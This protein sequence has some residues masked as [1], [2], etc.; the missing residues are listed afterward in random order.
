MAPI[1]YF[2]YLLHS[3][4]TVTVSPRPS[5][6]KITPGKEGTRQKKK[7]KNPNKITERRLLSSCRGGQA[8]AY[9]VIT[10]Q[11]RHPAAPRR[12]ALALRDPREAAPRHAG[13]PP[14]TCSRSR[15][16]PPTS[17]TAA[18]T[19]RRARARAQARA[20]HLSRRR[21]A[22]LRAGLATPPPASTRAR[23]R[24]RPSSP[25]RAT[26]PRARGEAASRVGRGGR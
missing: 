13:S 3:S 11:G 23:G 7:K 16:R 21:A 20:P 9:R 25:L 12:Q 2:F 1:Y 14:G 6:T 8:E 17:A 4:P 26:E 5:P 19:P 15:R 18:R 22:G 24:G 10:S